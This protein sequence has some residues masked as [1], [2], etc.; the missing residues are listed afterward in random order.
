[1]KG[2]TLALATEE[3]DL[4]VTIDEE[5]KFHKHVAAAIKK[6]S[7]M[8]GLIRAIFACLDGVTVPRLFTTPIRP[9]LE[10]GNIIWSPRFKVDSVKV[11][12]VQS[13][14]TKLIQNLRHVPYEDRLMTL[15]LPSPKYR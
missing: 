14:A 15:K 5:L 12:N 1:M 4:G 9:D 13:I 6:Y 3:T 10:Y 7:R 2:V 8:F 11:E